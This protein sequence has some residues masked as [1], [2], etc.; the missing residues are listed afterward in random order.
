MNHSMGKRQTGVMG[1]ILF[2]LLLFFI[3][4]SRDVLAKENGKTIRVGWYQVDG[5]MSEDANGKRYGYCYDF[6]QEIA[7]YTDYQYEYVEGTWNECL[8]R[9]ENGEIDVL[10]YAQYTEERDQYLDYSADSMG[11]S[12]ATLTKLA[13]NHAV[14]AGEYQTYQGKSFGVIEGSTQEQQLADFMEEHRIKGRVLTY[15]RIE[16]MEDALRRGEIDMLLHTSFRILEREE[17]VID[18]FSPKRFYFVVREGNTELLGE[19]DDAM[20]SI[21]RYDEGFQIRLKEKYFPENT[22][23]ALILTGEDEKL[24]AK[25]NG[26]QFISTGETGYCTPIKREDGSTTC[27]DELMA[28]SISEALKCQYT[29]TEKNNPKEV[30]TLL[31]SGEN[32]IL[33]GCVY[34]YDYA[35]EKGYY[36]TTPYMS[37]SYYMITDTE[38]GKPKGEN[39]RVALPLYLDYL[40]EH[41]KIVR[42]TDTVTY[43]NTMEDCLRAVLHGDADCAYGE[44]VPCDYLLD[45]YAYRRLTSA[46]LNVHYNICY[47]VYGEN[48]HE[49]SLL[50]SKAI[51]NRGTEYFEDMITANH[52]VL[53]KKMTFGQLVYDSPITFVWMVVL[54]AAILM[55]IF[56]VSEKQREKTDAAQ[57]EL[58]S[59]KRAS[60]AKSEFLSNMSHE[61]RTPMN[62]IIGMNKLAR[63]EAEGTNPQLE[64]YLSKIDESSEYLLGV[65]NDILDMSRIESGRQK[66]NLAWVNP[67]DIM[68]PCVDM[69][70]EAFAKKNIHFSCQPVDYNKKGYQIYTDAQK[71][72]QMLMNILNNACKFTQ[73]GGTVSM[74]IINKSIDREEQRA[75]DLITIRDNGCGMSEEFLTK[76]FTPFE[77]ERNNYTGAI[78]GTGL[79]LALSRNIARQMGGDITVESRLGE[80]STFTIQY[81]YKY[82][83][84]ASAAEQSAQRLEKEARTTVNLAGKR[85]LLAEDHPLNATIAT[86]LL[87]KKEMEV[88]LAENGREAVDLF[89]AA[90][91]GTFDAILMDVRMPVMDGLKATRTIRLLD[92]ADAKQIPIIAMT[93]NAFEEDREQSREAGMNAHLAKPIVPEE[94]YETLGEFIAEGKELVRNGEEE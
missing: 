89:E 29:F 52:P 60:E 24:L 4:G 16:E 58:A 22:E 87:E 37:A 5:V 44:A 55:T 94:L 20:N 1:A 75:T 6:Y 56:I 50:L 19:L 93:A 41:E 23:N 67:G 49:L 26:L 79:G 43:Y 12:Y 61:I 30:S 34:D 2:L 66:L 45:D 81:V 57:M 71:S 25:I 10:G 9:L 3:T 15:D 7:R 51:S 21:S 53:E 65:I 39:R 42:S 80:G 48:A 62:A 35:K 68:M 76:I 8:K 11:Q 73:A 31:E 77:Q 32:V 83:M 85:I 88:T 54:T 13:D 84:S 38:T 59:A 86:K 33:A 78:Q 63:D 82:R 14:V 69:M 40:E 18:Q 28:D 27:L 92:K 17:E 36:L 72:K 74:E 46:L 64:D 47:A 70:K 90:K 91:P